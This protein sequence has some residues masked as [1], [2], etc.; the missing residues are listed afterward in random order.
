MRLPSYTTQDQREMIRSLA[1][2]H[3]EDGSEIVMDAEEYLQ[4]RDSSNLATRDQ[5]L[6]DGSSTNAT[7]QHGFGR[8]RQFGHPHPSRHSVMGSLTSWVGDSSRANLSDCTAILGASHQQLHTGRPR[9]RSSQDPAVTSHFGSMI[10]IP[11]HEAGV[12]ASSFMS[13]PRDGVMSRTATPN[14][15]YVNQS[16]GMLLEEPAARGSVGAL[17]HSGPRAESAHSMST[18]GELQPTS[19]RE[20]GATGPLYRRR[21]AKVGE[22]K[23]QLP[24]DDN[25]YIMPSPQNGGSA[26]KPNSAQARYPFD[27]PDHGS[28]ANSC[29]SAPPSAGVFNGGMAFNVAAFLATNMNPSP[30]AGWDNPE[31]HLMAQKFEQ[32]QRQRLSSHNVSTASSPSYQASSLASTAS[33]FSGRFGTRANDSP[34]FPALAS[35]AV[36]YQNTDLASPTEVRERFGPTRSSEEESDHEYYNEI[37]RLKYEMKPLQPNGS[38]RNE[39]TV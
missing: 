26:K 37:D 35:T 25:D 15:L 29:A 13:M 32:Q 8:I 20:T 36:R 16:F 28:R 31:Y 34:S 2:P 5:S 12:M 6:S 22:M 7:H 33:P 38:R 19:S 4:P 17:R 11:V 9:R 18:T 10:G 39:T 30:T 21:D 27:V 24:L 1:A 3:I 23:L 14:P